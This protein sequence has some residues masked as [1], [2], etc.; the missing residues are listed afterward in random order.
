MQ[1]LFEFVRHH[2]WLSAG[3]LIAAV[4]V[5]VYELRTQV[6]SSA[7]VSAAEA[8]RL[9][10]Q[11]ALVVDLRSKEA[12]DA[13]HLGEARHVPAAE[14]EA[15]AE[16]LKKWREKPIVLYCDSGRTSASAAR[17]LADLGFTKATS[18]EGGVAA[19]VRDNLPL[20]KSGS[21]RRGAV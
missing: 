10:N 14:L 2:P 7:S 13:G 16:T 9:M 20:A 6:E 15:Q 12:Y 1:S 11:G 19:W 18:L 3:T 4:A 17:K 8:V 21:G 5:L